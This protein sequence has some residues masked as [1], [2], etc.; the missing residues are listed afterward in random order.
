MMIEMETTEGSRIYLQLS[1]QWQMII[2]II[3]QE[4]ETLKQLRI[5]VVKHYDH[6]LLNLNAIKKGMAQ[7]AETWRP[8]K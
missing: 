5:G 1:M 7:K 4:G 3:S 2:A 6:K 8:N